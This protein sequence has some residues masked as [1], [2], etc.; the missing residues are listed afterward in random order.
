MRQ[1]A[2]IESLLQMQIMEHQKLLA[3]I[4]LQ[5]AAMRAFDLGSMDQA[6]KLQEAARLR[7][8]SLETRRKGVIIQIARAA[9]VNEKQLTLARLAEL[10]PARSSELLKLRDELKSVAREISHKT[11]VAGKLAS[12]VAG[13]LNT[14]M[15]ILAGAVEKAGVYTKQGVPQVSARIGVMEAVG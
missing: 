4:E 7:I 11:N 8:A 5:H 13:H 15:R 12:A 1:L 6:A 10:N 14:V 3:H 2:E 9:K